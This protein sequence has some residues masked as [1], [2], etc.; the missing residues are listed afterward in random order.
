[1]VEV[2][3][4]PLTI[5]VTTSAGEPVQQLIFN[6]NNT[7]SF[8]LHDAPV[9]GLGEGGHKAAP[10][11]N[12]RTAPIEFDRRGRAP[13]KQPRWQADSYRSRNPVAPVGGTDGRALFV[14]APLGRGG[15]P[16]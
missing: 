5:K 9:L 6:D 13:E 8:A 16:A 7:L 3:P 2:S 1:M 14:A 10:G 12:W 15:P 4:A 11:V